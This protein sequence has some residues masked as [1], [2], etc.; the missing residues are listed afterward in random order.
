MAE[1]NKRETRQNT[2]LRDREFLALFLIVIMILFGGMAFYHTVEGWRWLDAFY[3][4]VTTLTTVG[5]GDLAPTT[6]ASKIFTIIFIF[7]GV[8][9]ILAL[10]NVIARHAQH[11]N[12]LRE[13]IDETFGKAKK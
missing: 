13:I 11:Q 2:L 6:D 7:V 1:L 10:I 5:Y 8:G 12:P 4:S 9:I 3:F